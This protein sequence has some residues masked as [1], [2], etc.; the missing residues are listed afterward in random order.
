MRRIIFL[1][2]LFGIQTAWGA[3]GDLQR[4]IYYYTQRADLFKQICFEPDGQFKENAI[5]YNAQGSIRDTA[6]D[7]DSQAIAL[8]GELEEIKAIIARGGPDCDAAIS[9]P[10]LANFLNGLGA[11]AEE[12]QCPGT[13]G[14]ASCVEGLA[15]NVASSLTP[16]LARDVADFIRGRETFNC[17]NDGGTNCIENLLAGAIFNVTD[18]GCAIGSL[19]GY[20]CSNP[21]A[22]AQEAASGDAAI[23]ASTM[24]NEDV[25]SF[26]DSPLQWM[27][28]TAK[29]MFN[30]IGETILERF[31]CARWSNP[32][33]PFASQCLEPT[34]W[35][36]ANCSTRLNM[37]CGVV[38]YIGGEILTSF[39][40]GAAVGL[41][42]RA[43]VRVGVEAAHFIPLAARTAIRGRVAFELGTIRNA[44]SAIAQSRIAQS[45]GS[46]AR[47]ASIRARYANRL[48]RRRIFLL[49][50]TQNALLAT[51]K[52]FNDLTVEALGAGFRASG[53]ARMETINH[54]LSLYPKASDLRSG[55]YASQ[56]IRNERDLLR[57]QSNG[58]PGFAV[59]R[60]NDGADSRIIVYSTREA[61]AGSGQAYDIF[62]TANRAPASPNPFVAPVV[63]PR[64][65]VTVVAAAEEVT[66]LP[67]VTVVASRRRGEPVVEYREIPVS[68]R[69]E[70]QILS[71]LGSS[72][73]EN[74]VLAQSATQ[75][76][77]VPADFETLADDFHEAWKASNAN[78]RATRPEL[79]RNYDEL[80][81]VE[82]IRIADEIEKGF[83]AG[84]RDLSASNGFTEYRSRLGPQAPAGSITANVAPADEVFD[85][86]VGNR[87]ERTGGIT[88]G[89]TAP[90]APSA[91]TQN[92]NPIAPTVA[93]DIVTDLTT[94]RITTR[95]TRGET[96]L[97]RF[98]GE[99][100][101]YQ[102]R[103]II[104]D[105]LMGGPRKN[106][107]FG[108]RSA[109]PAAFQTRYS[110]LE[111]RILRDP[112]LPRLKTEVEA[113]TL[114]RIA[115][116]N[117]KTAE[118]LADL[119]RQGIRSQT[120][121]IPCSA[122]ANVTPGA[123]PGEGNCKRI[124]FDQNVDGRY[125]SCGAMGKTSFTWLVR[126]PTSTTNFSSLATYVDELALPSDS[127]PEMCT[128][129]D[130]PRGKECYLGPTSATFA[131]FGGTTQL[132][133]E[134]RAPRSQAGIDDVA[135]FGL[136]FGGKEVSPV[137]WSPFTSHAELQEIIQRA[138]RSCTTV[139]NIDEYRELR[140]RYDQAIAAI[141]SR[142]NQAEIARLEVEAR[143]FE[144][145]MSELGSGR[146]P[147][148]TSFNLT[149]AGN[150]SNRQRVLQAQS[151]VGRVDGVE[152]VARRD[153][154]L[155]AHEVA[156]ERGFNQYS[157][158]E[159]REK[160]SVLRYGL[161]TQELAAFRRANGNRNP[162]EIFTSR[163]ADTLLRRGISG[164][165]PVD[166]LRAVTSAQRASEL[167]ARLSN[168]GNV[169]IEQVN[170]EFRTAA[171]I[172]AAEAISLNDPSK[173]AQAWRFY[174]RSGDPQS[175]LRLLEQ[176]VRQ[177]MDPQRV[178]SGLQQEFIAVSEQIA[179]SPNASLI[180]ERAAYQEIINGARGRLG[181]E[182]RRI[183]PTVSPFAAREAAERRQM[184]QIDQ[185][186]LR[187][188]DPASS[189]TPAAV[190]APTR[191]LTGKI[192]DDLHEAWRQNFIATN[193]ADAIRNKP[194]PDS[195]LRTGET[196]EA[197][198]ARL[199]SDGVTG[200]SIEDGKLVQNINQPAGSILPALNQKLNGNLASEYATLVQ[201][202]NF[203]SATDIERASSEVHEIWM[204]NN[205]WQREA[206]PALFRP[207][208]ELTAEEKIKDLDVLAQS[209]RARDPQLVNSPA[210]REYR[211]RLER[212]VR[213]EVELRR[214]A[215][216]Y[217]PQE[218][219][220][221]A[222]ELRLGTPT[223]PR[224]T[225]RAAEFYYRATND[226][227]R[228][229]AQRTRGYANGGSNF[230]GDRNFNDAFQ[231]SLESDGELA[232]RMLE[233]IR[234]SG[235]ETRQMSAV[236]SFLA[237]NSERF[238]VANRNPV[239]RA[240]IRKLI[241]HVEENYGSNLYDPQR[242]SMR[243]WA[244][245]N[246]DEPITLTAPIRNKVQVHVALTDEQ[247]AFIDNLV[248]SHGG[249]SMPDSRINSLLD[250][251]ASLG[252]ARVENTARPFR[253][254]RIT[255]FFPSG[256]TPD[257][258]MAAYARGRM[259]EVS[260]NG[261]TI[262][263]QGE[264]NGNRY[265]IYVC[266]RNCD[267][268]GI[269]VGRNEVTSIS[270]ECGPGI[271]ALP[272][273]SK[274]KEVLR[275]AAPITRDSFFTPL[276]CRD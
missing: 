106:A 151:L 85:T 219:Q 116:G 180:V 28:Q 37:I 158:P 115:V 198:L 74:R 157:Q 99:H 262:K 253:S 166:D 3:A 81:S 72:S 213:R 271:R 165:N 235:G 70:S 61:E 107:Y 95:T 252:G 199:R 143:G 265:T 49:A 68:T 26:R 200:L 133:C 147:Y 264:V 91:V 112:E 193:G 127:A 160:T 27:K 202:G 65:R 251:Q 82:K 276:P 51:V 88:I 189:R 59:T 108:G 185:D 243:S 191:D 239:V 250:N 218:A 104:L 47:Q 103:E 248:Q 217:N 55:V 119:E 233:D 255:S 23:I 33:L 25:V 249:R 57:F 152:N 89:S 118:E 43:A 156:P 121:D 242:R 187:R 205:E 10:N 90:R 177:G 186:R 168:G 15:C 69:T 38:G 12:A 21:N 1:I 53:A 34:S 54:L 123:F 142:S 241:S 101:T 208:N 97:T 35:S 266:E 220:R 204:R 46:V 216:S 237:E 163:E 134:H 229:E 120:R 20:E 190:V 272:K 256:T 184:G 274:A 269:R 128:R 114:D 162:P 212:D 22:Q 214:P 42:A 105:I 225:S 50:P 66:E 263:F 130:I 261:E 174:A 78:L 11:V 194:V 223:R 238:Q 136:D 178:F 154:L 259:T 93:D 63:P 100:V 153:A 260:R 125:C 145:Y 245:A 203:R 275:Q 80:S 77:R 201:R 132:L 244:S 64:P 179:R 210:Y 232:I 159:L 56:G 181:L 270:P 226:L 148:P 129:V 247:G 192:T 18:T 227:V 273:L 155:R 149:D 230:M 102:D 44:W 167:R 14:A 109:K 196:S 60:T 75:E 6:I 195:V 169:T 113:L 30:H 164:N 161:S 182:P 173:T 41:I 141:R 254:D 83:R 96:A 52:T 211:Q 231:Q 135:S 267:A 215:S 87:L 207:F 7:C 240:N 257:D 111:A 131:G 98:G 5:L 45:L 228:R 117:R 17:G 73:A 8:N 40:T 16:R 144:Q 126:C 92:V 48:A 206:N 76:F 2:L 209:L 24:R 110:E 62:G 172:Y 175:A 122:F 224:D 124:K 86:Q 246:F 58:R 139:C 79:F 67:P 146:R 183:D 258:V 137:R 236:N 84:G 140:Q 197:A 29:A 36:C 188:E 13:E 71:Q 32:N 176:G 234:I 268:N 150:F 4:K 138:S 221:I 222:N 39:F 31:G 9:D 19:F 170:N 94:G 171:Q